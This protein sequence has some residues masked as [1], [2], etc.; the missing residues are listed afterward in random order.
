MPSDVVNVTPWEHWLNVSKTVPR[1][2]F[3]PV[4]GGNTP[5]H[6]GD[7]RG[8]EHLCFFEFISTERERDGES[9]PGRGRERHRGR[10]RMPR[11]IREVS[12]EPSVGRGLD[13]TKREVSWPEPKLRVGR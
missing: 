7:P 13:L 4:R 8:S 10:D 11:R 3:F 6:T 12:T 1:V 2:P 9:K 5:A